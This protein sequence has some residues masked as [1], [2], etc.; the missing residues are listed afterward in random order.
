MIHP[1]DAEMVT[2]LLH[3][4]LN[5]PNIPKT[6]IFRTRHFL[7]H[8]IWL[9]C[10]FTNMFREPDVNAIVCNFIDISAQ[11]QSEALLQQ[12]IEEL[13]AY[14]YAIDEADI[15]AITDQKGVIKGPAIY[16]FRGRWRQKD[17]GNHC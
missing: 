11:K 6:C 3:E 5:N 4:V 16:S 9:Q 13:S 10:T 2:K 17:A 12:S 15:V 7:G 8:F 14:K 1:D